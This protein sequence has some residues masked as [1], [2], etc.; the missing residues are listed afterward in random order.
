MSEPIG[1]ASVVFQKPMATPSS[2]ENL[3][4]S[5]SSD[6]LRHLYLEML[7]IRMVEERIA[8]LYSEK[9]MRCPVHLCIGQEAIAVGVSASLKQEDLVLSGHRSHGHYLG[10][11]G[12]LSRMLAEIYGKENGC[13]KGK[14]GSMHLVDLSAGFL[15]ATPIVASSIPIAVGAAF[16]AM[17]QGQNIVIVVY[18]GEG[19]SEEGTFHESV[20]FAVLKNLPVIFVCENNLYSVYS[21][22]SVRQ[23]RT[24]DVMQIAEAHGCEG[25]RLDG[26]DVRVV[27]ESAAQ[28]VRKARSNGG[29]TF[30]EYE[31]YR[32][33]EHCGPNFDNHLG[34]RASSEFE[35]W[36]TRCPI[37][38][39]KEQL[40][41]FGSCA[42]V[43]EQRHVERL[44]SEI[45]A[46]VQF[47]KQSPFPSK[48]QLFQHIYAVPSLP[49]EEKA[50]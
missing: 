3:G 24:R 42:P 50:A 18:F 4:N 20:N 41:Q 40:S 49:V 23:P 8:D 36:R 46:A 47:A 32:W 26:N 17:L 38:N 43:W 10:K 12:D 45:E 29:P 5:L 2:M 15:G 39:T 22:L 16:G 19:A 44:S 7:R 9:E 30:L 28:A 35:E 1:T 14:G 21:P 48:D 27:Y 37:A 6:Y 34:Y 33:R 31:T 25:K 11:G 13:A